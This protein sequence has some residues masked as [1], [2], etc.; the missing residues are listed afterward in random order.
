MTFYG[1]EQVVI[2]DAGPATYQNAADARLAGRRI[3]VALNAV[4]DD[5]PYSEPA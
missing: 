3:H 4:I 5:D 2:P 1:F